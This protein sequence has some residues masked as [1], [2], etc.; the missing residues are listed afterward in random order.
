MSG[1][2][3]DVAVLSA[4]TTLSLAGN[5]ALDFVF[6]ADFSRRNVTITATADAPANGRITADAQFRLKVGANDPVTVTA[7]R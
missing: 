5:A 2:L 1:N 3:G 7:W 4:N 6:G